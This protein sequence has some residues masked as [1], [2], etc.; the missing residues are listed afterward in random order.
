MLLTLSAPTAVSECAGV[1][2]GPQ[3]RPLLIIRSPGLE[4]SCWASASPHIIL[5]LHGAAAHGVLVDDATRAE[6]R[7]T[8]AALQRRLVPPGY[9]VGSSYIAF[10]MLRYVLSIPAFWR[11]LIINGC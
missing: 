7:H 9:A 4:S 3:S 11:V 6:L 10:I 1:A 8:H 2:G 5:V